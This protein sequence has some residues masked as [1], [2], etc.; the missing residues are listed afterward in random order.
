[1][2]LCLQ[3]QDRCACPGRPIE[4]KV[5][6]WQIHPPLLLPPVWFWCARIGMRVAPNATLPPANMKIAT[7]RCRFILCLCYV[8]MSVSTLAIVMR[9]VILD[10]EYRWLLTAT[11]ILTK[12]N[13]LYCGQK[14]SITRM[15]CPDPLSSELPMKL[16]A[17]K[18]VDGHERKQHRRD[19][20]RFVHRAGDPR[21]SHGHERSLLQPRC[22]SGTLRLHR[23]VFVALL[24]SRLL[25][26]LL[27]LFHFLGLCSCF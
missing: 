4:C 17:R 14:Q 12:F 2:W 26:F 23:T 27:K 13:M 22:P 6:W 21:Q 15:P 9:Y 24:V 8:R 19:G 1:M 10:F 16:S 11:F 25:L 20:Q 7:S 18:I 3:Q 5:F